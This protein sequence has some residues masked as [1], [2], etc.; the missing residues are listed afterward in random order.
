[1]M[2]RFKKAD[3]IPITISVLLKVAQHY[4]IFTYKHLI[5]YEYPDLKGLVSTDYCDE[6]NITL[7]ESVHS[8]FR[9]I[10][11]D[12]ITSFSVTT[13]SIANVFGIDLDHREPD[14][15]LDRITDDFYWGLVIDDF[16]RDDEPESDGSPGPPGHLEDYAESMPAVIYTLCSLLRTGKV[17]L[18][19]D[20]ED[21]PDYLLFITEDYSNQEHAYTLGM[22]QELG[23]VLYEN[24]CD[25]RD[26]LIGN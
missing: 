11:G 22:L 5:E 1:M 25:L 2:R 10:N 12:T 8:R 20:W 7:L 9:K 21:N 4:M 23:G 16:P 26:V 17:D 3:R 14:K 19:F 13:L 24:F 18:D 6:S 15:R